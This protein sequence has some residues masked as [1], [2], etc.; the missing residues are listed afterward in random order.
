MKD[1]RI[2]EEGTTADI[3]DAPREAYT[4]ALMAAA[5]DVTRFRAGA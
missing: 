2:V 1:G 4:Q 3:F 5:I